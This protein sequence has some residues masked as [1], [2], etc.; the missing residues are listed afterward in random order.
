MATDELAEGR[1]GAV[2]DRDHDLTALQGISIRVHAHEAAIQV[3][4]RR[5]D[6][7]KERLDKHDVNH[8]QLRKERDAANAELRDTCEERTTDARKYAFRLVENARTE[9][10]TMIDRL[11]DEW[12]QIRKDE[13]EERRAEIAQGQARMALIVAIVTAAVTVVVQIVLARYGVHP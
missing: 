9:A 12:I 1:D 2:A 5:A 4:Q 8:E 7:H 6:D 13:K 10:K 3:L 11:S